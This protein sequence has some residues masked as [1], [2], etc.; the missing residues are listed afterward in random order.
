MLYVILHAKAPM[1]LDGYFWYFLP[2]LLEIFIPSNGAKNSPGIFMV[3]KVV[4]KRMD[5][6][7]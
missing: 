5:I 6:P 4:H 2:T 1:S 3:T 7:L